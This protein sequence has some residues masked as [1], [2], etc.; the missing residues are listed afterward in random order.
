MQRTEKAVLTPPFITE[1]ICMHHT[2]EG[3]NITQIVIIVT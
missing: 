2:E 1:S 3:D